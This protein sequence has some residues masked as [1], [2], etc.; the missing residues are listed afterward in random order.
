MS[1]RGFKRLIQSIKPENFGCIIR[2]VAEGKE[3]AELDKDL[4]AL[5]KMW[6][7]GMARMVEG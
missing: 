6:E 3:V 5:V 2:T 7:D 4:R 1:A